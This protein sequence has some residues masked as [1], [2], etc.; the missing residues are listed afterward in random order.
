MPL[1]SLIFLYF[2]MESYYPVLFRVIYFH[3]K[4]VPSF[5]SMPS[6]YCLKMAIFDNSFSLHYFLL[7]PLFSTFPLFSLQVKSSSFCLT[8]ILFLIFLLTPI[9]C[10]IP[11]LFSSTKKLLIILLLSSKSPFYFPSP[12]DFG[13]LNGEIISSLFIL[14]KIL[15]INVYLDIS[16]SYYL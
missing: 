2:C 14:Y 13:V 1:M 3:L 15:I 11:P 8:F 4:L 5:V 6:A 10:F 7:L 12:G 16:I 9:C